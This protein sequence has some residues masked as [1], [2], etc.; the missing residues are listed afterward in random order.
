M[1][2]FSTRTKCSLQNRKR[3]TGPLPSHQRRKNGNGRL[4]RWK[5][6]LTR[7]FELHQICLIHILL[8]H[9]PRSLQGMMKIL[10]KLQES[11]CL[12]FKGYRLG[13]LSRGT[14]Q[15]GMK[16]QQQPNRS[17]K[18]PKTKSSEDIQPIQ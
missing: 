2:L 7:V 11:Q 10:G 3:S 1:L 17:F 16:P 15:S 5:T 9:H 14:L 18:I 6:T 12:S 4:M 8:V 13:A